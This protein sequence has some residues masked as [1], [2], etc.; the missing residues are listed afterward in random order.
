MKARVIPTIDISQGKAVLIKRGNVNKFLNCPFDILDEYSFYEYIQIIDIDKSKGV[1]DNKD[2]IHKLIKKFPGKVIYGGGIKT[3]QE[4]LDL[5]SIGVHKI[6][7]GSNIH[8]IDVSLYKH[9]I[10]SFD[11]NY[12]LELLYNGREIQSNTSIL[13]ILN[14][15]N[16]D[17]IFITFHDLEGTG[18]GIDI[19][20]IK[21]LIK[22]IK[23][24]QISIAGGISSLQQIK[25]L[26]DLNINPVLGFALH[27]KKLHIKNI[28][29]LYFDDPIIPTIIQNTENHVLGLVY[30]N[31]QTLSETIHKKMCVF[32]S[33]SR[34]TIWFKGNISGHKFSLVTLHI[35]CSNKCLL[36]IVKELFSDKKEFCHN[37]TI[38]CFYNTPPITLS[39]LFNHINSN[40]NSHTNSYTNYLINNR[41]IL[42][43]KLYEELMEFIN[44]SDKK[45]LVHESSDLLYFICV[46]MIKHQVSFQEILYELSK[47]SRTKTINTIDIIKTIDTINTI[48]TFD[49][50]GISK[51]VYTIKMLEKLGFEFNLKLFTIKLRQDIKLNN[52]I[53]LTPK[54]HF[55]LTKPKD[56]GLLLRQKLLDG[57]IVSED[58]VMDINYKKLDIPNI[59]FKTTEIV[60]VKKNTKNITKNTKNDTLI[61][62]SEFPDITYKW[63]NNMNNKINKIN[64]I[65]KKFKIIPVKG[66]AESYLL[67]GL[68]DMCVVVCDTGETISNNNLVIVDSLFK[69]SIKFIY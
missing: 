20:N 11:I 64:R 34:N 26:L 31:K 27:T 8:N 24:T 56:C 45:N 49:R 5:L 35:N 15:I 53:I 58:C 23:N 25:I 65:N 9:I 36:F 2:I 21:K 50:I 48:K 63:M 18:K 10:V 33:R 38:S 30:S 55:I 59:K 41:D 4:C 13:K 29:P 43:M 57:A 60:I 40:T 39:T 68:C 12:K 62:C 16:Y 51:D 14:K 32:Y 1:G 61:I 3:N 52:D 6:I 28:I 44:F 69:A 66:T 67:N 17:H 37:N 19:T 54:T 7:I 47:R 42:V 46:F 22:I